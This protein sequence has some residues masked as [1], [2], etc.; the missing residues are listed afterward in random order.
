VILVPIASIFLTRLPPFFRCETSGDYPWFFCKPSFLPRII[1]QTLSYPP[2]Y[3]PSCSPPPILCLLFFTLSFDAPRHPPRFFWKLRNSKSYRGLCRTFLA[4]PA[5]P[6]VV[7]FPY[8]Q[9]PWLTVNVSAAGD[10]E[11][12][13]R[14]YSAL[15]FD[16][17]FCIPSP[18]LSLV[19]FFLCSFETVYPPFFLPRSSTVSFSPTGPCEF[20][21]Q[22]NMVINM[23][24]S[25]L[26]LLFG[27]PAF[28]FLFLGSQQTSLTSCP[29]L[30][31]DCVT[32]SELPPLVSF[33][34]IRY[35]IKAY[36]VRVLNI[37]PLPPS[38]P[39]FV[40]VVSFFFFL[41]RYDFAK[42]LPL[43]RPPVSY[44]WTT[45]LQPFAP[46]M[47]LNLF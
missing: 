3:P 24:S 12:T 31:P 5:C 35:L 11:A 8:F 30:R 13:W 47:A 6:A 16:R 2:H 45:H 25:R 22:T 39:P 18:I 38:S 15:F 28:F 17:C 20:V 4:I 43:R 40:Y 29:F 9:K 14:G 23:G 1:F 36:R 10:W 46:G 7:L 37:S 41:L 42:S 27:T 21:S 33:C 34:P 19:P 44:C 26:R 32:D